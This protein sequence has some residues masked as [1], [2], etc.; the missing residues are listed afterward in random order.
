MGKG[1]VIYVLCMEGIGI[2]DIIVYW[3]VQKLDL[4]WSIINITV[5][6]YTLQEHHSAE[7]I[8]K[9][10]SYMHICFQN[11]R[12]HNDFFP[13]TTYILHSE[14]KHSTTSCLRHINLIPH[15][16]MHWLL[17]H[18]L[19]IHKVCLHNTSHKPFSKLHNSLIEDFLWYMQE[20]T[21]QV[22]E[23]GHSWFRSF[24]LPLNTPHVLL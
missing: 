20:S 5:D 21:V 23:T 13:L 24:Q 15:A 2:S 1:E 3:V 4:Y 14:S 11:Y 12:D 16:L 22:A 18:G 7:A 10:A 9:W 19:C 6:M 8:W 17:N